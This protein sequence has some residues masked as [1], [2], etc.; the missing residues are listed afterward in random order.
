MALD[1]LV[2]SRSTVLMDF[3]N[4]L[5]TIKGTTVPK[6]F[7][8]VSESLSGTQNLLTN[9][10]IR[11]DGNRPASVNG[12][13]SA[14]GSMQII[15]T[16][17]AAPWLLKLFFHGIATTGSM[18]PYTHTFKWDISSVTFQSAVAEIAFSSS[19]IKKLTGMRIKKIGMKF[20]S[21][22]FLLWTI[23]FVALTATYITSATLIGTT[24]DWQ[25]SNP[26]EMLQIA[27]ADSKVTTVASTTQS[28]NAYAMR[29]IELEPNVNITED[30]YR[31]GQSG[32]RGGLPVGALDLGV[33]FKMAVSN[34]THMTFLQSS[35]AQSFDITFTESAGH[36]LQVLVPAFRV[37]KM[38][39]MVQND[40]GIYVDV[41]GKA[42]YD[43]TATTSFK[44]VVANANAGTLYA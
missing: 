6:K 42:E 33:K 13:I 34:A 31:I 28:G 15:S 8:I 32:A 26:F 35:S 10:S 27:A 29:E 7:A 38:L 24:T 5:G 14:S 37:Q 43:A 11:S 30:D 12:N 36:T 44:M 2:G 18:D 39:P 3:E 21:E 22:G 41:T 1:P 9:P 16:L 4:G 20:M 23:D 40:M 19:I 25:S 17:D